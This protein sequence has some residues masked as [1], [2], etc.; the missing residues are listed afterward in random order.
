[1]TNVD[2]VCN[3]SNDSSSDDE[4]DSS[5]DDKSN[6]DGKSYSVGNL[7]LE[8]P[9]DRMRYLCRLLNLIRY[10]P[11]DSNIYEEKIQIKNLTGAETALMCHYCLSCQQNGFVYGNYYLKLCMLSRLKIIASIS[12]LI[13]LM[14][15]RS[16]FK[17]SYSIFL[18]IRIRHPVML[19]N[20][21]LIFPVIYR[22]II[23]LSTLK[24][25]IIL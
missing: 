16:K 21:K 6:N 7:E 4:I 14:A 19:C 17:N 15:T 9:T 23:V 12:R 13:I 10:G 2:F 25:K 8:T 22:D 11:D 5:D 20:R 24:L 1:M 3:D 18:N